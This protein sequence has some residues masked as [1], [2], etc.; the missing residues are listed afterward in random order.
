MFRKTY[1]EVDLDAIK[2]NA[3]F[4]MNNSK[5]KIIG[6]VKA[7]GYGAVDYMEAKVLEETGVD[8]FAVSSLDEAL[9]LRNHGIESKILILGYSPTDCMDLIRQK[10]ISVVTLSKEYVEKADFKD[11]NVHIKLNT[12]MNRI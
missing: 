11:V 10:N 3:T 6:V 7:N 5:K 9:R 12:G 1:V 4:F 8:F 2:S